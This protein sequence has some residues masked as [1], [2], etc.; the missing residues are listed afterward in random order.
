MTPEFWKQRWTSNQIGFHEGR[1][2][3]LLAAHWPSLEVA[4]GG[5]V[6]VPLCGKSLDMVWLAAQGHTVLGIELSDIAVRDFFSENG[7]A[8][9]RETNDGFEKFRAGAIEIWCGDF[10]GLQAQR[11]A[12]IDGVYD[13]A[14]LF[15]MPPDMRP[16]YAAKM[17]EIVPPSAPTLLITIEYDQRAMAGPPFSVPAA[18]VQALYGKHFAIA[19]IGH[20]DGLSPNLAARGLTAARNFA[21]RLS[22]R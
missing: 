9:V 17:I 20:A 18:E 15:A 22:R 4:A 2:N 10:F 12:D 19:Q 16:A 13:R 11:L 3:A 6:F 21:F 1:V 14:S 5:R 7:I 8:P